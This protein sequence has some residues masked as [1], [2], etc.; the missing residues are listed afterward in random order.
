M[1]DKID[2]LADI[3]RDI[4]TAT[5]D[6][7]R[8]IPLVGMVR[9]T[10][11]GKINN[12]L[13]NATTESI[14]TTTKILGNIGDALGISTD[15][16]IQD[17]AKNINGLQR[18]FRLRSADNIRKD[19]FRATQ[20]GIEKQPKVVTKS[21]RK[22]GYKEYM[23]MNVRTT[24][25]HELGEMQLE[26][27]GDAGV[28]FYLCNT[29]SDSANDHAPF[30]GKYYYDMRYKEFGYDAQTVEVITNT[31]REKKILPMQYVR[32]NAPFLGTRPN[33]RHRF[34]PVS[35][36]QATGVSPK[37]ITEDLKLSTG[38]YKD[39][40]YVATQSLRAIELNI[41]NYDYKMRINRKLAL[42]TN[43][44][45]LRSKFNQL[46]LHNKK[47][48]ERWVSRR[49]KLIN[50]NPILREDK[51]R[52][53][54]EIL[55]NDM[56]IK[57]N[58]VEALKVDILQE[59]N[60]TDF[61]EYKY[62]PNKEL[63]QEINDTV[64]KLANNFVEVDAL[65]DFRVFTSKA[66]RSFAH[67]NHGFKY[68]K[69]EGGTY[70]IFTERT[71][72]FSSELF[73]DKTSANALLKRNFE[74]GHL[75]TGSVEGTVAHEVAHIIDREL[76]FVI[77]GK[78]LEQYEAELWKVPN[79]TVSYINQV[80]NPE[81]KRI[82][83]NSFSKAVKKEYDKL[84]TDIEKTISRYATTSDSEFFAEAFAKWFVN[85]MPNDDFGKIFRRLRNDINK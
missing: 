6:N 55:L 12:D 22:W 67:V 18:E 3:M 56:G 43:D 53:T 25:A 34:T 37:K 68:E 21:G 23:E 69:L 35:I 44:P 52:E 20:E 65:K 26:F 30:Q 83:N 24:L 36:Q 31:I 15:S 78:S 10:S 59:R 58:M 54:R 73:K 64:F 33:C 82:L 29:F 13:K 16:L 9:G 51:R 1:H 61:V 48:T 77:N 63:N 75:S 2:I 80:V 28:V 74:A 14:K 79:K 4:F 40:K 38:T 70:A 62:L 72:A 17:S 85:G 71:L 76:S 84:N 46:Y 32:E 66:N 39:S 81:V 45:I 57:Y 49:D 11:L 7:L 41:R 47:L 27:G 19:L 50:R 5:E 42:T 60:L 8:S